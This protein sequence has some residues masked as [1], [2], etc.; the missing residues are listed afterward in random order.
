MK[1]FTT[2]AAALLLSGFG[3]SAMAQAV[4]I[5]PNPE[6]GLYQ[7]PD[8]VKVS[9]GQLISLNTSSEA[10]VELWE[11][12]YELQLPILFNGEVW[13]ETGRNPWT[14]EETTEVYKATGRVYEEVLVINL[15]MVS[16]TFNLQ[17]LQNGNTFGFAIPAGA[18]LIGGGSTPNDS[19]AITYTIDLSANP[20]LANPTPSQEDWSEVTSPSVTFTWY[21]EVEAV[22]P[23]DCYVNV[24]MYYGDFNP[25]QV[26]PLYSNGVTTIYVD[27]SSLVA[28]NGYDT[29]TVSLPAGMFKSVTSAK[30]N[31]SHSYYF[32]LVEDEST[33]VNAI[34]N[35]N[36]VAEDVYNLQGV[37]MNN[38]LNSL[39]PGL[40]I[41]NGKKVLIRK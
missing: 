4:T 10:V 18:I 38:D 16:Q 31:E 23:S 2:I 32:F 15:G 27:W 37:K 13:T 20:Y 6:E 24:Y 30:E 36:G 8:E 39:A 9:W 40:Y 3:F 19:V 26:T 28:E 29:Y 17:Y 33:G 12:E 7:M 34:G 14:G 41:I 11:G 1:K 21:E 25:I 35:A 22:N 5:D